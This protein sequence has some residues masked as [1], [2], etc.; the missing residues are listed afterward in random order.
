MAAHDQHHIAFPLDDETPN[1]LE[2]TAVLFAIN[3]QAC[4]WNLA[5]LGLAVLICREE[6]RRS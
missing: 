6:E 4:T 3:M 5:V 1:S 2:Q